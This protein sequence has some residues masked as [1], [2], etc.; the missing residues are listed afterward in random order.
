MPTSRRWSSPRQRPLSTPMCWPPGSGGWPCVHR[1]DALAAICADRTAVAVAG[2]HGKT[3]TSALLATI[4]AGAGRDPGWVVGAGIPGLGRSATWGG[5]GPLVVEA[6]ESDGTFL[7]L[8][9]DGGHR[10]QRRARPPRALGR[11]GR[12]PGRVR[13]LRDGARRVQRCSALDDPGAAA[14]VA[15]GRRSGHLRHGPGSDYR[16]D[17]VAAEGTGVAFQLAPR[18]R[19]RCRSPC[20]GPRRS[21]T[22][23][24]RPPRW[25]WPTGSGCPWPTAAAALGRVPRGGPALRGTGRGGR[26]DAA[27]TATTT[28]PRRW[29]P[30]W[31]PPRPGR[32]GRVVCCFQPHRYSRTAGA[33]AD[34]S[35]MPSPTPTCSP[36]PTSTPA[37]EAPRPGVIGQARRGRG[38]RRPPVAAGGLAAQPLDDVVAVPRVRRSRPGDL[39]LTLG[40]GD[41][42]TVPDR[43]LAASARPGAPVSD[44][45][46]RSTTS[47]AGSARWSTRDVPLGPLTTYRVGGPAAL[48]AGSTTTADARRRGARAV[49]ATGRRRARRRQGLQP[50]GRRRRLRRAGRRARRRVRRGRHRRHH[51]CAPAGR[52]PSRWWPAARVAAG[53]DRL[54]V[55]GRRAGL[56]RRRRCG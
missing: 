37:G 48:L 7:A 4:L 46:G 38:A 41:L 49:A 53:L 43:V 25:P 20:R 5:A 30:R 2:T 15:R 22:P 52:R 23:A 10:H 47:P 14:L 8:G 36:S 26:R 45:G 24:T 12:A 39:C 3:T 16:I 19:A 32:W 21:T 55:G 54:R 28:C 29:R 35:P 42:T 13:A 44:A 40:A 51:A 56:D 50:A 1:A 9:A 17:D 31:R 27:S 18:R 6:D 33:R 34:A 11:R